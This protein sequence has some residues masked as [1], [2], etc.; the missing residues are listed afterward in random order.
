MSPQSPRETFGQLAAGYFEANSLGSHNTV[1]WVER[2]A[3]KAAQSARVRVLG[4]APSLS[5]FSDDQGV[6]P[7][8]VLYRL[9]FTAPLAG[10]IFDLTFSGSFDAVIE[11][12]GDLESSG[13]LAFAS[14]CLNRLGDPVTEVQAT[15]VALAAPSSQQDLTDDQTMDWIVALRN[16]EARRLRA[17]P[18]LS[19]IRRH[20]HGWDP[21]FL[22][23][24]GENPSAA[25]TIEIGRKSR[26]SRQALRTLL[27]DPI[28]RGFTLRGSLEQIEEDTS[29]RGVPSIHLELWRSLS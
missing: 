17:A 15:L 28:L 26:D 10:R 20:A 25:C 24:E 29:K 22:H 16:F 27:D 7:F 9:G 3:D 1:V 2:A 5:P 19:A 11:F 14:V 8:V 21:L 6:D 13:R 18:L 23:V 4:V 12:V